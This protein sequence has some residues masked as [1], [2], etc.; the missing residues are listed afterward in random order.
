MT[1]TEEEAKEIEDAL[2]IMFSAHYGQRDKAGLP[3]VLHPM[4]VGLAGKTHG[5]RVGGFLHDTLEDSS[6]SV[7]QLRSLLK[8]EHVDAII[9]LTK[10]HGESYITYL[11]RV[12]ENKLA[13]AIKLNDIADNS[14]PFR[15]NKLPAEERDR[16][17]KKYTEAYNFLKI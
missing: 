10:R 6:T 17:F 14:S 11:T 3:A 7:D 16:L 13:R 9:A 1:Q 4:R 5:E 12:K 8:A 15:L 2:A